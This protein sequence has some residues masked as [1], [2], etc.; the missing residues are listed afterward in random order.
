MFPETTIQHA[1]K[2]PHVV[3]IILYITHTLTLLINK[4]EVRHL[5]LYPI[6]CLVFDS[7]CPQSY[8]IIDLGHTV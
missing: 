6:Y 2:Y 7:P 8:L 4:Q 1:T 5:R 3:N